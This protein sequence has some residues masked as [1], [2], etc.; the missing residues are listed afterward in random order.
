MRFW[1]TFSIPKGVFWLVL[2][3][4]TVLAAA[5]SLGLGSVALGDVPEAAKKIMLYIRLPRTCAALLAGAALAAA[6]AVIQTVLHNPLASSGVLGVNSGAGFAVAV[7]CAIVP[8]AQRYTPVIAFFG[9]L[10]A[11]LLVVALAQ[12][13]GASRMTVVLAGVAMSSIFSAGIDAV[14]TF[15]PEA[16]GGVSDYRIGGFSGVTMARIAPAAVMIGVSLL[17]VLTLSRQMDVLALG[18][19]TAQSLGLSVAPVRFILLVLAAALSGAAVSFA[20][21][22]GFVGLIVPHAMRRFAGEES[23]PLLAASALG[24]ACFVT[25]CDLL[26]RVLFAPFELPV[27]VVLAVTGGPFF[28]WLLFRRKGG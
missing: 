26:A 6:G 25:L 15:V 18:S 21:L 9:A 5:L 16:L 1:R 8:A 24:G 22:L 10:A 20:G 4:L 3:A 23:G 17:A 11:V 7:V 27:G 28:L 12:C 13:T 14:V 2:S 19:E